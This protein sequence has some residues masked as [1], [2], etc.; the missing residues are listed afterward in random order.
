M[1]YS[2]LLLWGSCRCGLTLYFLMPWIPCPHGVSIAQGTTFDHI[3][4]PWIARMI[5][6]G[7]RMG[8]RTAFGHST[9]TF[10]PQNGWKWAKIE[11]N[12]RGNRISFLTPTKLPKMWVWESKIGSLAHFAC[13]SEMA[14]GKR[15]LL[16]AWDQHFAILRPFFVHQSQITSCLSH[17]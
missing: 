17:P 13:F 7:N 10:S 16:W 1:S 5:G 12:G 11:R 15:V 8:E 6:G 2:L 14:G 4:P 3:S 9:P